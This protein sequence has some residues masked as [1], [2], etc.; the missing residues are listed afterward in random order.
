MGK[1]LSARLRRSENTDCV[2]ELVEI[3][4]VGGVVLDIKD[5]IREKYQDIKQK[6][7]NAYRFLIYRQY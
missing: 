5:A 1:N 3:L 4:L 7:K 6:I 2:H